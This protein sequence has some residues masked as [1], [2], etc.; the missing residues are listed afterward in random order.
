[1]IIDYENP[2]KKFAE[3]FT[4]HAQRIG[5]AL[6]SLIAL[7]KRRNLGGDQVLLRY[8]GHFG[9]TD[10]ILQN[11]NTYC[12]MKVSIKKSRLISLIRDVFKTFSNTE[13]GAFYENS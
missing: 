13:D 7:Y 2:W 10:L 6:S 12:I 4:P 3:E 9:S 1:M 11:L 8:W 5:I